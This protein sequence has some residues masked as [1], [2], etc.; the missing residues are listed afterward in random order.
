[1][2]KSNMSDFLHDQIINISKAGAY[3]AI[4]DNYGVAL[5][6]NKILKKAI[7]DAVDLIINTGSE[8]IVVNPSVF[9]AKLAAILTE[10]YKLKPL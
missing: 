4:K 7:R 2:E 3:D 6:Q 1:M 9:V 5:E 8:D 10:T